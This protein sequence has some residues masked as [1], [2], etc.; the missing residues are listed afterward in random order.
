MYCPTKFQQ[1]NTQQLE[2]LI[3][4]YPFATLITYTDNEIEVNHLPFILKTINGKQVLQAHIAKAN[5]LWKNV[6]NKSKVMVVFNGPNEYISPN[7]YPTKKE[8][9]KVVPTWNYAVVHVKGDIRF[10]QEPSWLLQLI[11]DLTQHHEAK[12]QTPWMM[13][14]TPAGYINKMLPA[15]VGLEI[16][17]SCIQGKWKLSQNQPEVNKLGVVKGL[18]KRNTTMADLVKS[19]I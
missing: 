19:Q 2:A 13:S 4:D 15:I 11:G 9:G 14:D 18:N 10:I 1:Q 7:Y 6:Q 5:P 3:N 16:D 8:T 12:Q 17:I